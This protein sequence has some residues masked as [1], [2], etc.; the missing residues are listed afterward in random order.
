MYSYVSGVKVL[1]I[2]TLHKRTSKNCMTSNEF[3]L[4]GPAGAGIILGMGS[5]IERRR[6]TVTSSLIDWAHTQNDPY[7]DCCN[8]R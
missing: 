5:A 7:R 6:Y 3:Q 8:L 4:G 1:G 2:G